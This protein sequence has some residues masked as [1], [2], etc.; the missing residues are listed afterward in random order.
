M[1]LEETLFIKQLFMVAALSVSIT[2][3]AIGTA[4][5][6]SQVLA[7]SMG[8]TSI[9]VKGQDLQ[10]KFQCEELSN[11]LTEHQPIT[12]ACYSGGDTGKATETSLWSLVLGLL[13][14]IAKIL[15]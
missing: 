5:G 1:K 3:C 4:Q 9:A 7:I 15:I 12:L 8:G 13:G 10:M 11:G 6:E 2:A 14:S